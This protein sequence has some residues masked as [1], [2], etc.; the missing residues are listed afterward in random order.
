MAQA[1][2][3]DDD[4]SRL[5]SASV[6]SDGENSY[7]YPNSPV[8]TNTGLF[9]WDDVENLWELKPPSEINCPDPLSNLIPKATKA[10][11]AQSHRRF[12][13]ASLDW[14]KHG[15]ATLRPV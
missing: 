13:L 5:P 4:P 1:S 3:A 14:H 9:T 6:G 12:A 10:L 2:P 7:S 15:N 8:L 11:C